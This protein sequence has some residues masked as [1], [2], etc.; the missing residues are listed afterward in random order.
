MQNYTYHCHTNSLGIYDG[1]DSADAMITRAEELGFCEIG[2]SNHLIC[3]P[4]IGEINKFQE[5]YFRDYKQAEDIYKR[6]IDDIREAAARHKI[7][8][9]VG[10]EVDY[11][12][13]KVWLRFFERMRRNLAVDYFIGASHFIYND[14]FS[15][16][17]KISYLNK[18][19]DLLDD[20]ILRN[21]LKNHWLNLTAA[22][23]S[24]WFS[25]IAHL[26]QIMAKGFCN[27]P[28]WD[29]YKWLVIEALASG[30]TGFELSTK[31]LRKTKHFYPA[32]WIIEELNRHNVPLV[33]SDDAHSVSQLGENF[34]KAEKYLAEINYKRRIKF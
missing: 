18:R 1:I 3:N 34:D 9:F 23:R 32:D 8:V 7:K 24:G 15:K 25:F 33:V 17:L 11:F 22:I 4:A 10:F 28:Q 13:N 2:I 19:P 14:N 27:E 29:E 26:D 6:T 5:M 21:G 31:G 12:D 30:K 16:I 20:D